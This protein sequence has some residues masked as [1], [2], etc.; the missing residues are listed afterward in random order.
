MSKAEQRPSR[1]RVKVILTMRGLRECH[2]L[3]TIGRS[4]L[5]E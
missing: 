5:L 4:G 2:I 1:T 3:R